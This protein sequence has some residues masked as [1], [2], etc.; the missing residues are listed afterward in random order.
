MEKA[1]YATGYAETAE[2]ETN[3]AKNGTNVVKYTD[4]ELKAIAEKVK[5]DVWPVL[6]RDF[7]ALFDE[8][9]K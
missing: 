2:M 7:G 5:A 6:R 3:L 1:R 9:T 4:A 8:V